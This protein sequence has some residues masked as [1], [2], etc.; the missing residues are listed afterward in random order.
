MLYATYW[1]F[2]YRARCLSEKDHY[3]THYEV[4]GIPRN[5]S[6]KEIKEAYLKLSKE[7]GE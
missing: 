4:L 1:V 2:F 6:S 3:S 5:A 7:V